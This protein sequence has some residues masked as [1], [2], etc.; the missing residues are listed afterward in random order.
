MVHKLEEVLKAP[1]NDIMDAILMGFRAQVDVRGKLAE[2]Y[3]FRYLKKLETEGVIKNLEWRDK[4]GKPDFQFTYREKSYQMECKNLRNEIYRTPIPSYKVEIQRTRNS[5]D[6]T[7][8]RSYKVDY[9]DIL[10]A[11]TFNQNKRWEFLFIKAIDLEVVKHYPELLK[12]MQRVPI[13]VAPPWKKDL[14]EV[15][16]SMDLRN[17][18]SDK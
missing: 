3:L 15:L 12:I 16:E 5:K 6:G 8:T 18:A 9:F 1:A 2:L 17:M 4:D 13:T 14:V 7:N 10:A 11:C